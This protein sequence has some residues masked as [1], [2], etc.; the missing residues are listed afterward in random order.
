MDNNNRNTRSVIILDEV[1]EESKKNILE[2]LS[3]QDRVHLIV[4]ALSIPTKYTGPCAMIPENLNIDEHL[5]AYPVTDYS[6]VRT[7]SDHIR[8]VNRYNTMGSYFDEERLIYLI[9]LI[10]SIPS[11]NKDSIDERGFV[12]I[13]TPLLRNFFKDYLSYLDY[14]VR[15]GIFICDGQYIPGIISRG[16]KFAPQYEESRLIKYTYST[17]RQGERTVA[18]PTEIYDK[19][20]KKLTHNPLLDFPYLF[21]WYEQKLLQI[22]EPNASEYAFNV[23]QEK[24]NSG[25]TSWDINKD[26]SR[27][28]NICRKYPRSQYNAIMHNISSIA[29]GDYNAKIDSN[30]H[31]LHSAITNMQKKYRKFLS[32]DGRQL[33]SMDIAN[34]QPYLLC[35]LLNPLFWDKTSSININ[36]GKLPPNVQEWFS[37]EQISDIVSYLN[38]LNSEQV[39][40][41]ILKASNGVIYEYMVNVLNTG[42]T[43]NHVDKETV[44]TMILIVFFSSNRYFHQADA[45]LKRIFNQHFPAIYDLIK[46]TKVNHKEDLA[47]LLQ[48]LESEI[49]LHRCCKRIW[50]EGNHQVPVFT[51]HDSITT[52]IEFSEHVKRVMEEELL[53]VIGVPPTIKIEYWGNQINPH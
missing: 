13:N 42:N 9:G 49:I 36:I 15:T 30:V 28:G 34:C 53:N 43:S 12:H 50:E 11:K 26:K 51:I 10:S 45:E 29:A 21:Y 25:I 4:S 23:M 20:T 27:G 18:I 22:D 31:R 17:V 40:D 16:F 1:W 6:F 38:S 48:S 14:L 35:L 19:D 47:C 39:Q 2:W 24:F 32:Y 52:T 7:N 41:Y 8:S 33:V 46:L 3:L 5:Q 44:K 37:E